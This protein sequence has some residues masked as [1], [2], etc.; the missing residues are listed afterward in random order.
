[1]YLEGVHESLIHPKIYFENFIFRVAVAAPAFLVSYIYIYI[2]IYSLY[3]DVSIIKQPEG[4]KE[5]KLH[6]Q[7]ILDYYFIICMSKYTNCH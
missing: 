5:I 3:D 2:Y 7:V 6:A 1:M 4:K